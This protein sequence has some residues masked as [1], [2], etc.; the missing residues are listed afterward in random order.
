[1]N[2]IPL[3]SSHLR[4]LLYHWSRPR[5]RWDRAGPRFDTLGEALTFAIKMT[6][7]WPGTSAWRFHDTL[8]DTWWEADVTEPGQ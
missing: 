1:M 2:G 8:T 4:I 3:L 5:K 6:R 7:R